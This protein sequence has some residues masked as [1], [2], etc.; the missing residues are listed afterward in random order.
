[1]TRS[2]G[3]RVMPKPY[4]RTVDRDGSRGVLAAPSWSAAWSRMP[5]E[6]RGEWFE[7]VAQWPRLSFNQMEQLIQG[8]PPEPYAW[9]HPG[10]YMLEYEPHIRRLCY[11]IARGSFPTTA[12]PKEFVEW[13]ASC[14]ADLPQEFQDAVAASVNAAAAVT[15]SCGSTESSLGPSWAPLPVASETQDVSSYKKARGRPRVI[16]GRDEALAQAANEV[17][18]KRANEGSLMTA[19][20]VASAMQ[21][22]ALAGG[23]SAASIE[24]R[25][26]GKLVLDQAR[27]VCAGSRA[28]GKKCS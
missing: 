11:D 20:D 26:R 9:S 23:M 27:Q 13:C 7:H 24:R 2:L 3:A 22:T 10:T 25:L 8:L 16:V 21:G 14:A 17:L 12:T 4:T 1:M 18:M 15:S 28:A 6:K 19:K 5:S